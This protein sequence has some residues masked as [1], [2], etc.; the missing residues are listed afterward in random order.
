MF[1]DF[2]HKFGTHTGPLSLATKI[3]DSVSVL[4]QTEPSHSSYNRN[5][6]KVVR[7]PDKNASRTPPRGHVVWTRPADRRP[8]GRPRTSC[9]D[10]TS[11][12]AWKHLRSPVPGSAGQVK[13]TCF[14][15][16][17]CMV[18]YMDWFSL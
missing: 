8:R 4:H 12:L 2:V 14:S 17:T 1:K 5:P 7:A 11:H 10:Y 9:R 18:Y 16:S 6:V 15:Y 13:G 3:S